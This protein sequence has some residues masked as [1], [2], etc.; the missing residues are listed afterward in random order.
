[1]KCHTN[2]NSTPSTQLPHKFSYIVAILIHNHFESPNRC[3]EYFGTVCKVDF[4]Y[5]VIEKK[6]GLSHYY[7][8]SVGRSS[9]NMAAFDNHQVSLLGNRRFKFVSLTIV[10][11]KLRL[12]TET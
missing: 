7:H 2:D 5:D 11:F 12:P 6:N 10:I 8:G 3:S 9:L 4:Y 1:M